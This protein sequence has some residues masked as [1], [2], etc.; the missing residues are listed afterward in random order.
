[1]IRALTAL[2]L[3]IC[4]S[5]A[6]AS[7]WSGFYAGPM[8][9]E[10]EEVPGTTAAPAAQSDAGVCVRAILAAQER[11]EI[12][13]NILLGI[14]LQEAGTRR[15]GV[16][17]VWP[18]AANA[19]G[20]GRLLENRSQAMSW[21]RAQLANGVRSIDVGC[22]QINLR[23]HPEAFASLEEGFDPNRNADY[24]ARFLRDLYR[25]TGSWTLA[26]GSYH[27]FTPEMRD[28]YLASLRRKVLLANQE[29]DALRQL[30]ARAPEAVP[31]PA[32]DVAMARSAHTG[33]AIWSS[34]LSGAAGAQAGGLFVTGEVTP[35]M[36]AVRPTP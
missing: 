34:S 17:T 24:A 1:M 16:L 15:E 3:A 9:A 18:W 20:T 26:A 5:A 4:A 7:D 28:R 27:S 2:T 31:V 8:R 32:P 11:Y 35:L 10:V 30:S 19:E 36:Q 12:P 14:G 13:N 23:W 6:Q 29:I 25:Q 22:M 21:V 33:A